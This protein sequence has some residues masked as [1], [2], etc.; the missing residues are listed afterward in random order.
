MRMTAAITM[1]STILTCVLGARGASA[2][3]VFEQY[4]SE[5]AF[6]TRL[7]TTRVVNFDDIDTTKTDPKG[8]VASRYKASHGVV[9]TGEGSSQ[10]ASKDF[11]FP[12]EFI[13][14]SAPNSYAPGP[15]S[16]ILGDG[17]NS[18]T[19]TFFVGAQPATVA[20][21]GIV[22]IDADFPADG[23]SSLAVFGEGGTPTA[24]SG[25]VAGG[26]AS[27][28][29]QG[30]VAVDSN[31]NQPTAIIFSA[32]IISGQGWVGNFDNEGVS[33][34]DLEFGVPT[35]APGQAGENCDNCVD[36]DGDGYVDR[37]DRE[38]VPPAAGGGLGVGD[39]SAGKAIGKCEKAIASAGAGF[40]AAKQK[41]L[42]A[43]I[44][45]VFKCVQAGDPNCQKAHDTCAKSTTKI[46]TLGAKL[47]QAVEKGCGGVPPAVD[48]A[49]VL[50]V[51]GIGYAAE[52]SD[53]ADHFV[54]TLASAT[55]VATCVVNQHE[56]RA[57]QLLS[58]QNPRAQELA[59]L[60]ILVPANFPC[61]SGVANGNQQGIG[62]T[63][64][65]AKALVKCAAGLSKASATFAK[66]RQK[67]LQKCLGAVLPC[68]Q[69]TLG[70]ACLEKAQKK[71]GKIVAGL[72]GGTK[73]LASKTETAV[74]KACA[75]ADPA[76]LLDVK[77]L[78]MSAAAADCAAIGVPT[79]VS[80]S[81]FARCM[82]R[83]ETCRVDR[84]VEKEF[85]RADELF[86]LAGVVP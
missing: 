64:T 83:F 41:L 33:L 20:G 54:N 30:I 23:P 12:A 35:P 16:D 3:I 70:D 22:F 9:I 81:N 36:D 55:D 2:A 10:F 43:C 44:N 77:G 29:F 66:N 65:Q 80:A 40:V 13:P 82:V 1:A 49:N 58:D 46:G 5:A 19:I 6:A 37:F 4:T 69:Q 17:G 26:N 71:C 56:C 14:T 60:G 28:L 85:P 27:Q 31:T 52:A 53:C 45:A 21:V 67:A 72:A 62:G 63:P 61:I 68:V 42:Q 86:G 15:I 18:T 47:T 59:L 84:L 25:T 11:G 73:T 75:D 34:D 32:Q 7:G 79:M 51:D 50:A 8:F 76:D 57:E 39:A 74:T 78:G 48:F 24:S 38:C